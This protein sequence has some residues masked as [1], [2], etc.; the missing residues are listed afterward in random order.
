MLNQPTSSAMTKRIFGFPALD[1][2]ILSLL[3]SQVN[4]KPQPAF[5]GHRPS[6][7]MRREDSEFAS[8]GYSHRGVRAKRLAK[9]DLDWMAAFHPHAPF[10]D[11]AGK[12]SYRSMMISSRRLG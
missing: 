7:L 8:W 4:S 6:V 1:V 10:P 11:R 5:A 3:L 2:A 12:V 9:R